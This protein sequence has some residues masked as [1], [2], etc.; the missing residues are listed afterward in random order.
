MALPRLNNDN[1]IYEMVIPSTKK[2]IKYRPFLVKEQKNLL[3]AV[4]S[5]DAKQIMNS[6]LACLQSCTENCNIED[7]ATFDVDYMFTQIRSKSVGEKTNIITPCSECN[8]ENTV[9]LD[10]S[11]IQIDID[12]LSKNEIQLTNEI[13]LKMKYPTYQDMMKSEKIFSND[14]KMVEVLFETLILCMHSIQTEEENIL[15]KDESREEIES[16]INSLT[17][18]QLDRINIFVE[19][20]PTLTHNLEYRCE[21]CGH[22][23]KTE[24][25]GMQDFF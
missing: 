15:I 25:R 14:P 24:L 8:H 10:L 12:S 19:N 9:S 17:N 16:F 3:I 7:L 2:T 21:Q 11:G 18:E 6:M 23:N 20:L 4:E 1:P 22:E 13:K 5:Q